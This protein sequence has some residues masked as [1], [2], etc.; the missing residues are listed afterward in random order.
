MMA[1]S[2]TSGS[3][4]ASALERILVLFNK[5][6]REQLRRRHLN[7]ESAY[8]L[9][10]AAQPAG[11]RLSAYREQVGIP[12]ARASQIVRPL[13]AT[14]LLLVRRDQDNGRA[15]IIE[16]TES[17]RKTL[18]ELDAAVERALMADLSQPASR[19]S[20]LRENIVRLYRATKPPK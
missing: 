13:A 11:V 1:V 20:D 19:T 14:G 16:I 5:V 12:D 2:N 15:K 7:G 3:A 4:I 8:L 17:G 18:A 6:R 10:L 9:R